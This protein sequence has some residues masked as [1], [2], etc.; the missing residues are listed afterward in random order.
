MAFRN[1]ASRRLSVYS[2]ELL[3]LP[4][5]SSK[6]SYPF[7]SRPWPPRAQPCPGQESPH[8]RYR[9]PAARGPLRPRPLL[10][11]AA[12]RDAPVPARRQALPHVRRFRLPWEL[13]RF[14]RGA[15]RGAKR[16]SQVLE[17]RQVAAPGREVGLAK[18]AERSARIQRQVAAFGV[19][20]FGFADGIDAAKCARP[21]GPRVQ[22]PKRVTSDGRICIAQPPTIGLA[23][24]PPGAWVVPSEK[25]RGLT[26]RH[27]DS[28]DGD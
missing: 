3:W 18:T 6:H 21:P 4:P 28:A 20:T 13:Y 2:S 9:P 7:Q 8:L 24:A 14:G 23:A 1:S 19:G 16:R 27:V 26:P 17:C 10:S 5:V 12:L 22:A 15:L 11:S 25:R